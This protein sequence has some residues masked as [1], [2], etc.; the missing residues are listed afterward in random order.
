M[1]NTVSV[2][3]Y[4]ETK[5]RLNQL[6]ECLD[7]SQQQDQ[8]KQREIDQLE[9]KLTQLYQLYKDEQQQSKQQLYSEKIWF[10]QQ[11]KTLEQKIEVTVAP[12]HI[13]KLLSIT[14]TDAG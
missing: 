14:I 2:D 5:A 7:K 8:V 13:Q 10:Q 3:E 12:M 9:Q 6:K 1:G 11:L 4:E